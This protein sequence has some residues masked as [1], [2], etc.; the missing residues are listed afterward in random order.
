MAFRLAAICLRQ[1]LRLLLLRC[2]SSRSKDLEL[3]VL[4]QE[5]DVRQDLLGGL[6][7]EYYR[8]AA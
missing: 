7:H 3:L 4:R 2:L 5:L 6:I 1:I 8:R